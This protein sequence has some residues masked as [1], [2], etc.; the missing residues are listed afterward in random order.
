[1]NACL[2]ELLGARLEVALEVVDD[3]GR[4]DEGDGNEVYL[5]GDGKVDVQ[6]VLRLVLMHVDKGKRQPKT[7]RKSIY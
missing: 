6:P 5:L 7:L 1:M 2:N 4:L 3:V